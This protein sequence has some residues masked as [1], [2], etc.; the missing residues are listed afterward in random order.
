MAPGGI[1]VMAAACDDGLPDDGAFAGILRDASG[2][3]ELARPRGPGRLDAWQAQVLGRVL[4]RAEVWMFSE[5]LS[6]DAV[7][8]A[9]LSPVHDLSAAVAAALDRTGPGA[10]LCVLPH[11]PL[12]VATS[13]GPAPAG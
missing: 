3:A 8:S 13:A 5:G 12:T 7:R 10:R 6:D 4:G 1:I 11:G 2:P 9:M